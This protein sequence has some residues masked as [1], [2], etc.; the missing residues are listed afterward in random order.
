[1]SY[2]PLHEEVQSIVKISPHIRVEVN[3][4][5]TFWVRRGVHI[6]QPGKE[7]RPSIHDNISE[8]ANGE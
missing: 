5:N 1:M 8:K 2:L 4:A 6:V 7:A 3:P